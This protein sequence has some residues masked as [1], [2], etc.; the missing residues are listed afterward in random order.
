MKIRKRIVTV[1]LALTLA[2]TMMPMMGAP[3]YAASKSNFYSGA[4]VLR[5]GSN[6]SEAATVHMAGTKW[7][8]IG[9]GAG[10]EQ[11]P[12]VASSADTM[13][14]IAADNLQT[15]VWFN[16]SE[17]QVNTYKGS[18]LY[19]TVNALTDDTN[20]I[21]SK[22]EK[23]GVVPRDLAEGDYTYHIPYT[24]GIAGDKVEG[25][26]LWPLSTQ[27]AYYMDG[28]LR[29]A[30]VSWWF[31]SPGVYDY[32]A[33]FVNDSGEVIYYGYTVESVLGVRPAI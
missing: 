19:N 13:T 22:G 9:Y 30:S 27:E 31:R 20:G 29:V 17:N 11:I 7:R 10:T 24:N 33:A 15:K 14:L 1:L 23:A 5:D 28:N 6:T 25:A 16:P 12:Q 3:V 8:V 21:F 18:T 32:F 4:D 2:F 26:L